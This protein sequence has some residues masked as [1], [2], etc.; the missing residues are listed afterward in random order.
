MFHALYRLSAG[1]FDSVMFRAFTSVL[2]S[3]QS[4]L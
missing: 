2:R 3:G 4:R 1:H